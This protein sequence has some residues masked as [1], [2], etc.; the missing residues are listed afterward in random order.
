MKRSISPAESFIRDK[1]FD[2]RGTEMCGNEIGNRALEDDAKSLGIDAP[3]HDIERVGPQFF[4]CRLDLGRTAVTGAQND[5]RRTVAEQAGGDDI[6]LGQFIVAHRKRAEFER[7]QEHV[8][9]GPRLRKPRRDR[10]PRHAARAAQ[11]ENRHARHVG[12]KAELAGDAR[13]QRRR[14]DAGRTYRDDGVDLVGREIGTR[15][16]L[17]RDVDE[18]GFRAF[19]KGLRPLGPAAPLEIPFDG[20]DPVAMAD[21]GIGKQARKRLELRV[22]IGEQV[23]RSLE[24]LLLMELMRRN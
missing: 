1:H 24:D 16:S 18:Q 9:A 17:A 21:A 6:G 20:L 13:L 22:T 8:G 2:H 7:D 15:E 23:V 4:A 11:T 19:Q 5:G 12:A 3:A 14:R 10:Q